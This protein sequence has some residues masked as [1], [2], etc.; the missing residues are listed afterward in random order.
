MRK[1][2]ENLLPDGGLHYIGI[3]NESPVYHALNLIIIGHYATLSHDPVAVK[4][5]KDTANY[6]PLVLT[7]RLAQRS[8]VAGGLGVRYT[9][10][11]G[12]INGWPTPQTS[13]SL[14]QVTQV[15]RAAV[16]GLLGMVAVEVTADAPGD[17]VLG[18]TAVGP[19]AVEAPTDGRATVRAVAGE[20]P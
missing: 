11:R 8:D 5:L 18:R 16:D 1:T 15:W 19:G 17:V 2:V 12:L 13:P 7:A 10:Q 6:W 4:L 20:S 3:E 9:L 14:W